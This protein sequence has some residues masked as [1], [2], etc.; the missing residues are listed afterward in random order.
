MSYGVSALGFNISLLICVFNI[1]FPFEMLPEGRRVDFG[2]GKEGMYVAKPRI[3][4]GSCEQS[5]SEQD[6]AFCKGTVP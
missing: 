1:T 3:G 2:D 5:P 4:K 6:Q